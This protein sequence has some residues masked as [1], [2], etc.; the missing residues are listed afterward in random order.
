VEKG[1]A[2]EDHAGKLEPVKPA[3]RMRIAHSADL[4]ATGVWDRW[5]HDCF[6][7]ER[8][9]PFKQVFRELYLLT[10][11][12]K[13]DGNVSHR[14]AGQQVQ[15]RQGAALLNSRGW[16]TQDFTRP[17][18][19]AGIR[20]TFSVRH[21][22]WTPLDVEGWTLEDIRFFR[23][24]VWQ[25]MP[26]AEVPPRIFSEAMRDLDL[27][28]S[29]AHMGQIDP[30]ASASTTEMRAALL[31]ET[32]QLLRLGNVRVETKHVLIDGSLGQ[33]SVHLGSGTVHRLPGG[34]VCIVP[35][36]AQH[37]GRLFLPFADDDP[38][39]AEIVSKVLLLARDGEIQDPGILQQLLNA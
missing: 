34:S 30:E 36:H 22:G 25:P 28:V 23:R 12:E 11:Q 35:V 8:V 15:P 18:H 24:D 19:E 13:S 1:P 39:T 10:D 27:I 33:Y 21:G 31:R 6:A 4:F 3:E 17:F 9:Q 32:T 16:S 2:L 20:V 14:Y 7:R 5:Q 38:R 37:R 29:V 26:L